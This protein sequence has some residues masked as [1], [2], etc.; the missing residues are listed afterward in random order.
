VYISNVPTAP[1]TTITPTACQSRTSSLCILA[2]LT[3]Q[4]AALALAATRVS[5]WA[6]APAATEIFAIPILLVVQILSASLLSPVLAA[7]WRSAAIALASV[8]PFAVLAGLLGAQSIETIVRSG[9]YVS[10]WLIVLWVWQAGILSLD[11]RMR[12]AALATTW[13]AAGP[14]LLFIRMEYGISLPQ[15]TTRAGSALLGPIVGAITALDPTV[16]PLQSWVW[17]ELL[18]AGLAGGAY[19]WARRAI[20]N[21]GRRVPNDP[22]TD[23]ETA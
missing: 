6:R 22:L 12:I 23:P 5:L 7:H 1:A 19:L 2:W 14:I 13:S 15:P 8:W 10:G 21:G 20:F 3:I 4:A 18:V 9:A 11:G 17:L 16:F